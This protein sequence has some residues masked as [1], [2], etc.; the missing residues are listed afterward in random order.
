MKATDRAVTLAVTV[1]LSA[2]AFFAKGGLTLAQNTFAEVLLVVAGSGL[3]AA[4]LAV[5]HRHAALPPLHGMATL[6]AFGAL[7]V[8]TA[9]SIAWSVDPSNSW[10]EAN[11]V[12]AYFAAFAGA[13]C[14]ARLM[15]GRSGAVLTGVG[16]AAVVICTWALLTKVLPEWLAEDEQVA[17]LRAPFDY[18]NAVGLMAAL[19]VP[20][21]LWLAARRTGHAARSALAFPA[22]GLLLVC[23]MLTYSRGSLLALGAGLAC[24]FALVPLRLRGA[25]ALIAAAVTTAGVVAW[26][27]AQDTLT[28]DKLAAADRADSGL[29]LGVLL[30]L[31]AVVLLGI[32]L[33]AGFVAARRPPTARV[34]E[35]TGRVL[36]AAVVIGAAVGAVALVSGDALERLTDPA[37]STPANDPNRLTATASVRARYWDEAFQVHDTVPW[38][39]AGAG[40]FGLA[41]QR[42]RTQTIDVAHAHGY[43]PQTLADLGW[44]GLIVSVAAALAW[45]AAA[46][47][48]VEVRRRGQPWDAER[49]AAATLVCVVVVF[50][51]HSLIDWTWFIPANAVAALICAGFVAGRPPLL[52]RLRVEGPTGV[53]AAAEHRGLLPARRHFS[54]GERLAAWNPS[55]YRTALAACVLGLGMALSWSIVQ[56][57]RAENAYE[58]AGNRIAAGEYEAAEEIAEIARDRNP[59]SVDP[60]YALAT[61]RSVQGDSEGAL[62]ALQ[63]AVHTQPANAEAWRR[64]G[65]YQLRTMGDPEAALRSLQAAYYL[66]PQAAG[67]QSELL[68]AARA[69]EAISP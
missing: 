60:Y 45:L 64:L 54:A 23:L 66:D 28:E 7:A 3:A 56:P 34:R 20:P 30:V 41:R 61:A 25:V 2:L 6:V 12:F 17:R 18:W 22:L 69:A 44:V 9:L 42:F 14:L 43:V 47:R 1:A 13:L 15:P 52:T 31:Q 32:G 36:V 37:A 58:A 39:G 19:G 67:R 27:F 49:V 38:L 5:P 8:L 21:M 57:L 40:A 53:V 4:A 65:I 29:A 35:L 63:G 59:L 11:R 55:P 26:A 48:V 10:F 68:E 50:G 33:A 62:D 46:L 24:W 16:L 51:V